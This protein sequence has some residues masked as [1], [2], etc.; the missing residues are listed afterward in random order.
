VVF[1]RGIFKKILSVETERKYTKI[2][3]LKL[4]SLKNQRAIYFAFQIIGV[5][6]EEQKNKIR[7]LEKMVSGKNR[8]L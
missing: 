8:L 7:H 4:T 3:C 2:H 5:I 6:G 1:F